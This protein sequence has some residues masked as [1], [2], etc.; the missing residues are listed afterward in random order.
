MKQVFY[1]CS[2]AIGILILSACSNL[3]PQKID[4]VPFEKTIEH[5]ISMQSESSPTSLET[6]PETKFIS[7][8]RELLPLQYRWTSSGDGEN[9]ATITNIEVIDSTDCINQK[10]FLDSEYVTIYNGNFSERK[11]YVYPDYIREDG[12]FQPGVRMILVDVSVENPDGATS[13]WKNADGE[14]KLHYSSPYVFNVCSVCS[15]IYL[16]KGTE[17]N[18]IMQ[19]P[20]SQCAYFSLRDESFENQC[21]FEL[22][23]N[24]ALSF[25]L[26]FL[27]GNNTDGSDIDVSALG[28]GLC[29]SLNSPWVP[30][31]QEGK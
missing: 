13:R 1:F 29:G 20:I 23:P 8:S 22:K 11:Q 14:Y 10:G 3:S 24:S 25:Q 12:C 2:L 26:G 7:D 17:Y 15:L 30:V 28:V 21:C 9:I 5:D 31:Y 4:N 18:G 6:T 27:V 16:D 19:C